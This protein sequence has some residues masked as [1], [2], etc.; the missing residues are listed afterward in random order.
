MR[1]IT[2]N[3]IFR[4][5]VA[6]WRVKMYLLRG[7]LR[8]VIGED[9]TGQ[10][11]RRVVS[12]AQT[13][14]NKF[15]WVRVEA[16][17]LPHEPKKLYLPGVPET[18]EEGP[19]L[20][21]DVPPG[22]CSTI[23]DTLMLAHYPQ[24]SLRWLLCESIRVVDSGR[25]EVTIEDAADNTWNLVTRKSALERFPGNTVRVKALVWRQL[26]D[27]TALV[28]L[29]EA[30]PGLGTTVVVPLHNLAIP[31]HGNDRRGLCAE[32]G[33]VGYYEDEIAFGVMDRRVCPE[34]LGT[35]VCE[36]WRHSAETQCGSP[37]SRAI[38]AALFANN[39]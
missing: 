37:A 17:T 20:A 15:V 31:I 10:K 1:L 35:C 3:G 36:F 11:F 30:V 16:D 23:G 2:M 4:G 19:A 29:P 27:D 22:T 21:V 9:V 25:C 12:S 8:L 39:A 33:G 13:C 18:P 14:D 32:C 28:E 38:V 5:S 6:L 7:G 34:C 26:N 24:A